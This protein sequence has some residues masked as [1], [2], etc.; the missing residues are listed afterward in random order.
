MKI[1]K[2]ATAVATVV[3][4]AL[5]GQ[6]QASDAPMDILGLEFG[7]PFAVGQ[8]PVRRVGTVWMY[9]TDRSIPQES[10]PCYKHP[11]VGG[12]GRRAGDPMPPAGTVT[13]DLLV[14]NAPGGIRENEIQAGLVDGKLERLILGTWGVN[15]QERLLETLTEKYGQPSGVERG[16]AQ[17]RMGA[18]FDSVVAAW[19]FPN[20]SVRFAGLAGDI[21]NGAIIVETP[22]GAAAA[23]QADQERRAR[24]PR[25]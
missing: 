18:S 10:Y 20:L 14:R 25:L 7:K 16:Q 23:A 12:D 17:N 6:A 5:G 4:C 8:C 13:V 21:Y 1:C 22:T 2:A 11:Y 15:W 24:E 19:S 9:E 3:L